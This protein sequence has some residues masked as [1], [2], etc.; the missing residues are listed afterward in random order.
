LRATGRVGLYEHFNALPPALFAGHLAAIYAAFAATGTGVAELGYGFMDNPA[1]AG[2]PPALPGGS[3][4]SSFR[5]FFTSLGQTPW[6]ALV[7]APD[8]FHAPGTA[9]TVAAWQAQAATAHGLGIRLFLP[10]TTPNDNAGLAEDPASAPGWARL[11]DIATAMGGVA[12]DAPPHYFLTGNAAGPAYR[13]WLTRWVRWNAGQGLR[14][15][16]LVSPDVSGAEFLA[17]TQRLV[18]YLG[19]HDAL[20]HDWVVENYDNF[21]QVIAARVVQGGT[22]Y[23]HAS[24]TIGPPSVP[25]GTQ[26]VANAHV[27]DGRVSEIGIVDPGSGYL[28]ASIAI[29]GD[30]HGATG[31]ASVG[32]RQGGRPAGT[33][34]PGDVR[35]P[36]PNVVG[37]DSLPQSVAG[38]AL[39]MA[40]HAPVRPCAP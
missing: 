1:F 26:A 40:T 13:D 6:A 24:V 16:W 31:Q 28:A 11:R 18:A 15:F 21:T 35:L 30:G 7:N 3:P 27:V 36:N 38:V 29:A 10:V 22:G 25:W 12:I 20:P 17:D 23:T 8:N 14:V 37:R 5:A 9:Q 4:G 2:T 32:P 34:V 19:A 39:W 33:L